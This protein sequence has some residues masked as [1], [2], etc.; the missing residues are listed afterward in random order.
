MNINTAC[1][2]KACERHLETMIA[3]QRM[4]NNSISLTLILI[5]LLSGAKCHYGGKMCAEVQTTQRKPLIV[6]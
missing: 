6:A 5:R 4:L 3:S 1:L 2:L